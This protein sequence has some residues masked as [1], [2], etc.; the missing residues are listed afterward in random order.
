[1]ANKY[2]G[3]D[4]IRDEA[5]RG[6]LVPSTILK[7]GQC[8]GAL[9]NESCAAERPRVGI[10]ADTRISGSMINCALCAGLVS[11]GAD[12]IDF[13]VLPTP[14]LSYL[15][16][17]RGLGSGIMISASHN[18]MADNGIKIFH[19]DGFKISDAFEKR[20]E[21]MIDGFDFPEIDDPDLPEI[22]DPD[23]PEID[24][25]DLP[26]ALRTGAAVGRVTVDHSGFED[27]VSFMV[28][29]FEGG[30]L[31]DFKVA[32]DCANGATWKSAPEILKRL[33]AKI[34]VM[35]NAPNGTNINEQCGSVHPHSLREL[36]LAEKCDAGMAL[37][38]DG[39]R[40]ILIDNTGKVVDG[41]M[42]MA[43]LGIWLKS[44]G[45]LSHD[46]VVAT[47]MSN[48]GLAAALRR[49]G[50]HLE[51]TSVGDRY[52]TARMQ[53]GDFS[54][55]GEQSGHIIFGRENNYTGDGAYT[56]LRL[57]EAV[58]ESG[59]SLAE[60]VSGM[61]TF[62][63]ILINV[64]VTRKLPLD[65]MPAVVERIN[66][67]E[68]VLGEEGRVVVRYSGT[69]PKLR[70]MIE[71]RDQDEVNGLAE[72]IADAVRAADGVRAADDNRAAD[73]IRSE[74]E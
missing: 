25:P 9:L 72:S 56:A 43:G 5:N 19:S 42:V 31:R 41:D 54:L 14:A 2:F 18:P 24:D 35:A 6:A 27:Y 65:E 32:V 28:D 50:I 52:V 8:V 53:E 62:P 64:P 36:V 60:F 58:V 30:M 55:G 70:V 45:A 38:G 39:D 17:A 57:F 16:R 71:G 37:D 13:G 23:L 21:A 26:G 4:G 20:L 59:L 12:V 61:E 33:G 46:T 11:V 63:Q 1:M 49:E 68:T 34:T 74:S 69:E 73:G 44:K 29:R 48:I 66:A 3:T 15:T 10:G 22:D 47:V 40:C 51:R 67:A 7:V